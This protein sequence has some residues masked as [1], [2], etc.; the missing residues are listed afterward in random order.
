MSERIEP[1]TLSDLRSVLAEHERFWGER[2]LRFLHL[3][4]L[5]QEFGDT[6]LVARGPGGRIDG[7]LLGFT[8][9]SRTG[10]IHAVAVRDEARGTGCATALYR[11]FAAAAAGHGA[12]RLKAITNLINTGSVA[13]HRRL[14]FHV[15]QVDDYDG[16]G[17]P[18]MVMTRPLPFA[19]SGGEQDRSEG[20]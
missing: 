17:V 2:D 12:T 15:E 8:T 6:C 10:Y 5:V 13:Y 1:M 7:Y 9:P 11:A 14:G 16:P 18:M 20:E 4:A 3:R 19:A